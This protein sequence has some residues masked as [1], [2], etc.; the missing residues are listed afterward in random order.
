MGLITILVFMIFA[1]VINLPNL[2]SALGNFIPYYIRSGLH[3][4]SH[5]CYVNDWEKNIRKEMKNDNDK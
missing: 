3:K 1:S 4:E 5:H 2:S